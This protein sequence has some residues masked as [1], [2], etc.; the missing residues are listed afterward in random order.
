MVMMGYGFLAAPDLTGLAH[1][2]I[3][4]VED[5]TLSHSTLRNNLGVELTT[6]QNLIVMGANAGQ[7]FTRNSFVA[8]A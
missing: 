1:S 5:S 8:F 2:L 6:L 7:N 3:T 4:S